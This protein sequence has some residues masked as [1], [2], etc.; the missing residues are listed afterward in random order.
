MSR[1]KVKRKVVV[2]PQLQ[3][4]L[5]QSFLFVFI[6]SSSIFFATMMLTFA[7][8]QHLFAEHKIEITP[9][10]ADGLSSLQTTTNVVFGVTSVVSIF[11]VIYGGLF[12]SR[13]IAG[14]I[15]S[16]KNHIDRLLAGEV[17]E[18]IQF[19]K[20]DYFAEFQEKFNQLLAYG[21]RK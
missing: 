10:L 2:D 18:N 16:V 12:L 14:P 20:G 8:I 7:K 11:V 1:H 17:V 19:R 6:F 9:G 4:A 5:I 3:F 13:K 15:V 21:R